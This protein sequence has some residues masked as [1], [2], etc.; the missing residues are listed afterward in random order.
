MSSASD[1]V[2]LK[3]L[4]E[5]CKEK[6]ERL[7]TN[8]SYGNMIGPHDGSDLYSQV[9]NDLI[10]EYDIIACNSVGNCG[11]QVLVHKHNFSSNTTV[12]RVIVS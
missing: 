12:L 4:A 7:V 3:T 8:M 11:D 5:Y 6:G 1:L 2:A 10:K 9:L